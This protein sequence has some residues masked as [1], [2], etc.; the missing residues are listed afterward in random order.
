MGR[1]KFFKPAKRSNTRAESGWKMTALTNH[2]RS[3]PESQRS[4]SFEG[5]LD[6]DGRSYTLREFDWDLGL[7]FRMCSNTVNMQWR[8]PSPTKKPSIAATSQ[9][10]RQQWYLTNAR[11]TMPGPMPRSGHDL[12]SFFQGAID[13]T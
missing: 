10:A 7:F 2:P 3:R 4:R 6:S 1:A 11:Q 12:Q 5:A 8:W 9:S 13:F